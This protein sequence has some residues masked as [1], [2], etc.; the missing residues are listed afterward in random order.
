MVVYEVIINRQLQQCHLV[1]EVTNQHA[2]QD[3]RD[4]QQLMM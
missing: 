3:I 4:R 2:M 1:K